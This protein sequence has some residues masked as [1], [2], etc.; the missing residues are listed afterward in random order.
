MQSDVKIHPGQ[1]QPFPTW[2]FVRIQMMLVL[3]TRIYYDRHD[4]QVDISHVK[5]SAPPS[6][7]LYCLFS[8]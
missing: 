5:A 6:A 1:G 7:V 3:Y 4:Y 2:L 8:V